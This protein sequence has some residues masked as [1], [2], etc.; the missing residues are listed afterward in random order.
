MKESAQQLKNT[1]SPVRHKQQ[2]DNSQQ[3]CHL[4]SSLEPENKDHQYYNLN[5][6]KYCIF[7]PNT[8]QINQ[9]Y[10][11][12]DETITSITTQENHQLMHIR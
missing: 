5:T 8:K 3:G 10:S 7:S 9:F 11:N 1:W 6:L 4:L 12:L 2:F